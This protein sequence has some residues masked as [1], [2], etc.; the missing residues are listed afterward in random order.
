M[1]S[2]SVFLDIIE[3]A[4]FWLKNADANRSQGVCHVIHIFFGSSLGKVQSF[5]IIG[6][7]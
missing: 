4:D 3:F 6:Y 7:V 1:Q 5:I 2:I